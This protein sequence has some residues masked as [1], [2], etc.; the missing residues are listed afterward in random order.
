MITEKV[1]DW[2]LTLAHV[3]HQGSGLDHQNVERIITEHDG[4]VRQRA[5]HTE[6]DRQYGKHLHH[7]QDQTVEMHQ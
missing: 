3:L 6:V 4:R 1:V 5:V 2:I 7:G